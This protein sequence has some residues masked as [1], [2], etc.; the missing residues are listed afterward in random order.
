MDENEN[1]D[2]QFIILFRFYV[3]ICNFC[4]VKEFNM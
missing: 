2:I 4:Y 1:G 3:F